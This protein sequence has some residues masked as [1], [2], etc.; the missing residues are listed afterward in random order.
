MYGRNQ[1]L[2]LYVCRGDV[3][4]RV[5]LGNLL[6]GGRNLNTKENYEPINGLSSVNGDFVQSEQGR[7]LSLTYN[8][9]MEKSGDFSVTTDQAVKI[10]PGALYSYGPYDPPYDPSYAV[11]ITAH[12]YST[13]QVHMGEYGCIISELWTC[14]GEDGRKDIFK[15]TNCSKIAIRF[16]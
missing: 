4:N 5:N 1:D 7:T 12:K 6:G 2:S 10:I 13:Y 16:Y 15:D 14:G 3:C 11:T 8:G 9:G